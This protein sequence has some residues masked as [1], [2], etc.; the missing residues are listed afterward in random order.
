MAVAWTI[1]YFLSSLFERRRL[2]SLMRIVSRF[3]VWPFLLLDHWV[4]RK[5]GTYDCGSAFYFFGA[6]RDGP[7]HDRDIVAMYKGLNGPT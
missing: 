5:A 2:R 4:A 1:E 6:L 3:V 7:I